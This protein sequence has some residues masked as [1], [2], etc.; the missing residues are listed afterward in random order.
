MPRSEGCTTNKK[1]AIN[2]G[3]NIINDFTSN[4]KKKW[5]QMMKKKLGFYGDF[6]EDEKFIKKILLW[7]ETNNA[8]YTNTFL[9]LME[10]NR[11]ISDIYNDSKWILFFYSFIRSIFVL[12]IKTKN[13]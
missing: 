6:P 5:Q 12:L 4:F 8:D 11:K 7:M 2:I 10:K 1:K 3:T 9:Y 13:N